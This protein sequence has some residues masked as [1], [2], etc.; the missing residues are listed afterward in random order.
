VTVRS[1]V[2]TRN[3][4]YLETAMVRGLRSVPSLA[5]A[6]FGLAIFGFL[7]LLIAHGMAL[8][9]VALAIIPL[10]VLGLTTLAASNR[11]ILLFSGLALGMAGSTLQ[12]PLA[13]TGSVS[14]YLADLVLMLTLAAWATARLLGLTS[15]PPGR[16]RPAVLGWVFLPFALIMFVDTVRGNNAYGASLLGQPLR[17]II[18]AGIALAISELSARE[19]YR[20]LVIVFYAGTVIQFLSGLV[21]LATGTSQTRAEELSTGGMRY[22]ALT[23]SLY[24]T[25]AFFLALLN[26]GIDPERRRRLIH[27]GV[28]LLALVGIILSFGRGTFAGAALGAAVLFVAF[29]RVRRT[30]LWFAPLI[31]IGL[32]VVSLTAPKETQTVSTTLTSRVTRPVATDP[33]VE[34]RK[35]ANH[36]VW[37][38]FRQDPFFGIGFGKG[39]TFSIQ[40]ITYVIPQD[41]HNDYVW[42]LAGGG[43]LALTSFL[44]LIAVAVRDAVRR[45][46]RTRDSHERLLIWWS[47]VTLSAFL[48]NAIAEPL[49]SEPTILLTIWILLLVPSVVPLRRT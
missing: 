40:G 18:Y 25:G 21:Y 44:T 17:F 27:V 7:G 20:G 10:L 43:I 4:G 38:Q 37:Q 14:V 26:V 16:N 23:T 24:L 33:T 29:P 5:A 12:N 6:A 36:M 45:L 34:W 3:L 46:W 2:Q 9:A 41:P 1:I 32:A 19:V 42:L 30:L 28:A 22:L 47:L 11:S 35:K 48:L 39:E 31:A 49:M 13:I 8:I 15:P